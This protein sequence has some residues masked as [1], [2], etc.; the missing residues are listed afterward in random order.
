MPLSVE[1]RLHVCAAQHPKFQMPHQQP[2]EGQNEQG[3]A[4]GGCVCVVRY[5]TGREVRG[6]KPGSENQVHQH[7]VPLLVQF[8]S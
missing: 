2:G 3:A 6:R 1:L 8:G 4:Q 5:G 7:V